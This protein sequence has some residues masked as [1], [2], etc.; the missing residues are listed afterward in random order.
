MILKQNKLALNISNIVTANQCANIVLAAGASPAMTCAWVDNKGLLKIAGSLTVNMG[1]AGMISPKT[2]IKTINAALKQ[3]L[4]IVFDPVG[5]GA[6]RFRTKLARKI[7]TMGVSIIRGNASEILSLHFDVQT[8]GVDSQHFDDQTNNY[9]T[10]A[11]KFNT[12]LLVTGA[13]DF[14]VSKDKVVEIKGGHQNMTLK[15]G[16]GCV[17]ASLVGALVTEHAPFEAA[18]LG[19]Q[20]MKK[21]GAKLFKNNIPSYTEVYNFVANYE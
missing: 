21:A 8:K 2:I 20:I 11:K 14:V 18:V 19:S 1:A 16:T 5:S 4:P 9:T 7:A 13:K 10:I 15:T 3:K 12:I 17:L 6:N